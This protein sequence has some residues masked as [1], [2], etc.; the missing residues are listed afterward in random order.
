MGWT[1]SAMAPLTEPSRGPRQAT[2]RN[3]NGGQLG[4]SSSVG[5]NACLRLYVCRSTREGDGAALMETGEGEG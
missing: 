2:R 1:R 3:R 5:V 4:S